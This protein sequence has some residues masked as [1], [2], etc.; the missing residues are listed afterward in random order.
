[1]QSRCHLIYSHAHV[2]DKNGSKSG[3]DSHYHFRKWYSDWSLPS[4]RQ[5]GLSGYPSSAFNCN[6]LNGD[7]VIMRTL[8]FSLS[9][10]SLFVISDQ[11]C[12]VSHHQLCTVSHHQPCTV[13]HHQPCTVSHHQ[14]CTVSH[15]QLCTVS[16]HQLCTVSHHQLC[17][18]SHHQ[19]CTVSHHQLCTVSHHQLCIVSHH[20]NSTQAAHVVVAVIT[21]VDACH[22]FM[23][24]DRRRRHNR[25]HRRP[26]PGRQAGG[27]RTAGS[28]GPTRDKR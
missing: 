6:I 12:T 22:K 7:T 26:P 28:R 13:S 20:L 3:D 10:N 14:L 4:H 23:L 2:R 16:H 27:G 19:L 5:L 25:R 17:T 15:H 21:L 24:I 11:L 18:V 9:C 8:S 1:M